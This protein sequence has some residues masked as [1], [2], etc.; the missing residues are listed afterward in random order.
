MRECLDFSMGIILVYDGKVGSSYIN[1]F[2]W[3]DD[4][5]DTANDTGSELDNDAEDK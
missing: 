2:S 5:L 1:C 4:G 3:T